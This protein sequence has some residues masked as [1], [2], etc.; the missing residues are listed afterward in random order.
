MPIHD[1]TRVRAG[2]FHDFHQ[3]WTICIKR[4][5]NSGILPAGYYAMVEQASAG[6]Y[7]D[8]LSFQIDR[9]AATDGNSPTSP[10]G[11]VLT[12]TE[13]PPRTD[14][15]A[16]I[17]SDPFVERSN[18]VLAFN[19]E[20]TVVAVIEIVSPGNKSSRAEF[21]SFVDKALQFLRLG[22]HLLNVDLFPPTA[23]D[24][25]GLHAAIWSEMT[26][27]GYHL[28]PGK[29]LTAASYSAG[30]VKRAFANA[31]AIGDSL[32]PMPLFLE[33]EAYVEVPL[34]ATYQTAF[35]DVPKPYRD[36]LSTTSPC[37]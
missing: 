26:D 5:L 1:W 12:L 15:T 28:P 29:L 19:E 27:Y 13:S 33:P 8:V 24:P 23:R 21:Q 34:E 30:V 14:I 22:I 31:L 32:P 36:E 17:E 25:N 9:P 2:V 7:P 35:D 20:G 4:A 6:R 18:R 10:N 11:G 3:E 16:S 37:S